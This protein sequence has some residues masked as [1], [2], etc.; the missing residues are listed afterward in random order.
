MRQLLFVL[1]S[2]WACLPAMAQDFQISA[3]DVLSIEVLQDPTLNRDVLVL[4]DGSI[5]FPFAGSVRASGQT[6]AQV[7]QS[8]TGAIASNFA[9]PPNVFVTVRQTAERPAPRVTGGPVRA[10]TI[11]V[12][13][14]GEVANP[15]GIEIPPGTTFLQALALGGGFTDFAAL[16]RVQ[17]RRTDPMTGQQSVVEINYR[18]IENGAS[19]NR[20]ITMADGDIILVPERRL[21][22]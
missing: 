13:F 1:V 4:P 11:E 14:M 16:R 8:L 17:L 6:V 12:Y 10:R 20:D 7:Q 22:E 19:L 15:G 5:N 9:A 3:G 2:L 18:A 21:F